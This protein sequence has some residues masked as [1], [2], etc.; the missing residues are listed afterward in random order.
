[1]V[2]LFGW[3]YLFTG[4]LQVKIQ[5]MFTKIRELSKLC[6]HFWTT[7]NKV[8]VYGA[9]SLHQA[10]IGKSLSILMKGEYVPKKRTLF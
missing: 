1:M 6:G 4:K 10:V 8:V 2:V 9:L 7:N 3:S 5:A